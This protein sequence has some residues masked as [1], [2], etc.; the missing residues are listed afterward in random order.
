MQ[1][2]AHPAGNVQPALRT[3]AVTPARCREK[4]REPSNRPLNSA[5]YRADTEGKSQVGHPHTY[6]Q[7]F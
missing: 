2:Y 5:S 3:W 6:V 4:S 7:L 1:G